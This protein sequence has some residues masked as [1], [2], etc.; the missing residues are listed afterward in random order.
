[1]LD[2]LR[3]EFEDPDEMLADRHDFLLGPADCNALLCLPHLTRLKVDH[4]IITDEQVWEALLPRLQSLD[5]RAC[6]V[7]STTPLPSLRSLTLTSSCCNALALI[8]KAC[9]QLQRSSLKELFTP[10]CDAQLAQLRG[11]MGHPLWRSNE[12][13]ASNCA[14]VTEV[15]Q[16]GV[17]GLVEE[18][19]P[20]EV[21][22]ALPVMPTVT[23][24]TFCFTLG[25]EGRQEMCVGHDQARL[26]HHLP[27]VFPHLTILRLISLPPEDS[28][29]KQL[30]A[31][32]S[33]GL[34]EVRRCN[35]VTKEALFELMVALPAL[36]SIG[37][38]GCGLV[39]AADVAAMTVAIQTARRE[40]R[41]R[42]A[43]ALQEARLNA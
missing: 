11:I 24:F 1:M 8:L 31:C 15:S 38:A 28:D 43:K 40:N 10:T 37:V 25:Q 4:G 26:L 9:P 6:Y 16:E 34:L 42:V 33:L 41:G 18:L 2:D 19:L 39:S 27:R 36:S 7:G 5:L 21:L 12:G 3:I 32:K 29:L 35:S 22:Q 20:R 14:P 17:A 30:Y 13:R 23:T